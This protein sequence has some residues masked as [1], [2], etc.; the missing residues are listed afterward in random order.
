[1]PYSIY[2]LFCCTTITRL[3]HSK[4]Q[5]Q[6][7]GSR[8]V[9]I[10]RL[11]FIFTPLNYF[12]TKVDADGAKVRKFIVKRGRK[13]F[14]QGV[15]VTT[16]EVNSNMPFF[17]CIFCVSSN[18]TRMMKAKTQRLDLSISPRFNVMPFYYK[19]HKNLFIIN[20][21]RRYVQL[22]MCHHCQLDKEIL[23]LSIRSKFTNFG[24]VAKSAE[25]E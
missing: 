7:N 11:S 14:N 20:N 10:E 19:Q 12:M 24:F 4:W 17:F 6:Y 15:F 25:L 21:T 8:K 5:C 2:L 3:N 13:V 23:L 16:K 22:L 18:V 9:I 1:M